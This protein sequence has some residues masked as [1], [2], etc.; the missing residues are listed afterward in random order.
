MYPLAARGTMPPAQPPLVEVFKLF[1]EDLISKAFGGEFK[2]WSR[3][4]MTCTRARD[5]GRLVPFGAEFKL[6]NGVPCAGMIAALNLLTTVPQQPKHFNLKL[7]K[8]SIHVLIQPGQISSLATLL[9]NAAG[10]LQALHLEHTACSSTQLSELFASLQGCTKMTNLHLGEL[11][12]QYFAAQGNAV[13]SRFASLASLSIGG[14]ELSDEDMQN[15]VRFIKRNPNLRGVKF[16]YTTLPG[17]DPLAKALSSV[18]SLQTLTFRNVMAHNWNL[19]ALASALS[20]LFGLLSIDFHGCHM[21]PAHACPVI[22]A[23]R[24]LPKLQ[25]LGLG[26]NKLGSLGA[27]ALA[28]ALQ[29]SPEIRNL[30]WASAGL[31]ARDVEI[32]FSAIPT[33]NL[34]SLELNHNTI[35]E[36]GGEALGKALKNCGS[37]ESLGLRHC[38]IGSKEILNLVVAMGHHCLGLRR[39]DLYDNDLGDEG[40][41][42]VMEPLASYRKLVSLDIG[43][44]GI[45]ESGVCKIASLLPRFSGLDTLILSHN[46][47]NQASARFLTD[48]LDQCSS[49]KYVDLSSP[50]LSREAHELFSGRTYTP[51]FYYDIYP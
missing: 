33:Q 38:K 29:N 51:E 48:A 31:R 9:K 26:S 49:L 39:L 12:T 22:E 4:L 30:Y 37:L 21:Q 36:Q 27:Q 25:T 5:F 16:N 19:E 2:H 3:F 17:F 18:P 1:D 43:D 24:G 14:C 42:K 34:R 45:G 6:A 50:S 28:R 11:A 47:I 7:S 20:Q 35:G 23:M 41:D 13:S 10:T 46:I 44:N 40:A 8:L 15:L 32:I